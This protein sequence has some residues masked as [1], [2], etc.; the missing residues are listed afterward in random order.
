MANNWHKKIKIW[1]TVTGACL[2]T[3]K[4]GSLFESVTSVTFS[5]D[6][7][8]LALALRLGQDGKVTVW[9]TMTWRPLLWLKLRQWASSVAF[10]P[11]GSQLA[12]GSEDGTISI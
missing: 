11:D 12:S 6:G 7:K 4:D 3:L 2:S 8:Q 1:D 5:S 9:D 10:S